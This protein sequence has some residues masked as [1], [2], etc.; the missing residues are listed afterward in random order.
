MKFNTIRLLKGYATLTRKE[1]GY[2]EKGDTISGLDSNPVEVARFDISEE[3]KALEELRKHHC[4]YR[5]GLEDYFIEEYALEY[6]ACDSDG[7]FLEGSDYEFAEEE[8]ELADFIGC[9]FEEIP[10]NFRE[11]ILRYGDSIDA[12]TGNRAEEAGPCTIDIAGT[13]LSIPGVLLQ[14]GEFIV[15]DQAVLY[16]SAE[17]I[18]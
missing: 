16:D 5:R 8:E 6:C 14:C 10:E 7:D 12:R 13:T 9:T 3:S 2:F 11:E 1:Y 15:A 4:E 17:G 18:R